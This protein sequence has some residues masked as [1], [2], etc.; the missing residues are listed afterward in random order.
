M[1]DSLEDKLSYGLQPFFPTIELPLCSLI[2]TRFWGKDTNSSE[3]DH[4]LLVGYVIDGNK[5]MEN[6]L[7]LSICLPSNIIIG[8]TKKLKKHISKFR[9][10]TEYQIPEYQYG[11]SDFPIDSIENELEIGMILE[12]TGKGNDDLKK[13]K[14]HAGYLSET[15]S[16]YLVISMDHPSNVSEFSIKNRVKLKYE[17]IGLYRLLGQRDIW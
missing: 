13:L 12:I 3:D 11:F 14:R 2:E 16:N 4:N 1:E 17:D 15:A 9:V 5:S 6:R 7:Q 8:K 10:L